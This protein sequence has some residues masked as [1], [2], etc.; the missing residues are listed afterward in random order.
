MIPMGRSGPPVVLSIQRIELR[1]FRQGREFEFCD[2]RHIAYNFR[3]VFD[4][5]TQDAILRATLI[6][7]LRRSAMFEGLCDL[8]IAR[9]AGYSRDIPV[10]KGGVICREGDPVIGFYVV[11]QGVIEAYRTGANGDE[12]LIH[13]VHPGET[14]AEVTVAGHTTYPASARALEDADVVLILSKPFLTHLAE[15]P[16][17]A[18]RM[19]AS[20]SRRI[21]R[22]VGVIESYQLRDAESR[23]LRWLLDQCSGLTG[24]ENISLSTTRQVLATELGTRRETLS[25]I[26]TRLRDEG[27]ITVR[28]REIGIQDVAALRHRLDLRR[29]REPS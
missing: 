11:V 5:P 9:V 26:F 23:L 18:I 8:E 17:L 28:G 12:R 15:H 27:M 13:L 7:K 3:P 19:L 29:G 25:R 16:Q 21:H 22:L 14:F 4:M 6:A 24:T 20:L 1:W 10:L 2:L